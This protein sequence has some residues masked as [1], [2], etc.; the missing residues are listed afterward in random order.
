MSLEIINFCKNN[1]DKV[2][3]NKSNKPNKKSVFIGVTS[4]ATPI[5]LAKDFS[6]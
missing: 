3:K 6:Y 5:K 4:Y 2:N 1:N